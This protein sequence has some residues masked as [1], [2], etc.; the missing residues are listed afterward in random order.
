MCDFE[1][2]IV[3]RLQYSASVFEKFDLATVIF[4][5]CTL[6]INPLALYFTFK[7]TID[8]NLSSILIMLEITSEALAAIAQIGNTF[9]PYF[10]A[11]PYRWINV[12]T[13]HMWTNE[14]LISIFN[15]FCRQNILG[16]TVERC[17][18]TFFPDTDLLRYPKIIAGIYCFSWAYN[19]VSNL[20]LVLFVELNDTGQC[21]IVPETMINRTELLAFRYISIVLIDIIP[22]VL[23]MT[24][25]FL[26]LLHRYK[27]KRKTNFIAKQQIGGN[28][29]IQKQLD[30]LVLI[31]S[32]LG[33]MI[34]VGDLLLDG[35]YA[36]KDNRFVFR[37]IYQSLQL[38]RSFTFIIRSVTLFLILSPMRNKILLCKNNI[39]IYLRLWKNKPSI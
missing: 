17:L 20:Y 27:H 34:N 26:I 23:V 1:S 12:L 21:S 16:M 36:N 10:L 8:A 22:I 4:S 2:G 35:L 9:C 39:V 18:N 13:C 32:S 30:C 24:V 28:K 5:C 33:V 29:Q 6:L 19:L 15:S 3:Y 37:V 25:F 7:V 31:W 38:F 11:T 14:F